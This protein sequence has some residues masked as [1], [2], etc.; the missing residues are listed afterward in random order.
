M[1]APDNA[2]LQ[3]NFK[4]ER[5]G[6]MINVYATNQKEFEE[7]LTTIQ[8]TAALFLSVEQT[9]KG[10]ARMNGSVVTSAPAAQSA[11]APKVAPGSSDIPNCSHGPMIPMSGVNARGPWSGLKCSAPQGTKPRCE[12]IYFKA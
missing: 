5:D 6:S 10:L 12:P 7:L 9:L 3:A 1:S 8:D 4:W 11:P 2:K